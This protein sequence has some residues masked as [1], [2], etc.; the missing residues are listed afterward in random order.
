MIVLI[1]MEQGKKNKRLFWVPAIAPLISVVLSTL[2]VFITRADKE[3]VA[4]VSIQISTVS[5]K[6]DLFTSPLLI[7]IFF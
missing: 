3:G 2:L 1:D 7:C 6:I 5:A 4:I